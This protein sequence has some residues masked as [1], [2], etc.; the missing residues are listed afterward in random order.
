MAV[1]KIGSEIAALAASAQTALS[2]MRAL[3]DKLADT[4]EAV[5][6]DHEAPVNGEWYDGI[7]RPPAMWANNASKTVI[8]FNGELHFARFV[9]EDG[10]K[11]WK[12]AD[13]KHILCGVERWTPVAEYGGV[14]WI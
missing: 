4:K 6:P 3:A 2:E 1:N 11:L 12:T 14:T 10:Q 13:E 7:A 8:A 5:V 9:E